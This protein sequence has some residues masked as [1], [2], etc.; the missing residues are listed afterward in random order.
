MKLHK[1]L[2]TLAQHQRRQAYQRVYSAVRGADPET[3]RRLLRALWHQAVSKQ[4]KI[5]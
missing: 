5:A 3:R 2:P 1:R 4:E